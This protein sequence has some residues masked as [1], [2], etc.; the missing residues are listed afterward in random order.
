RERPTAADQVYVIAGDAID[1]ERLDVGQQRH[2]ACA[3]GK[4]AARSKIDRVDAAQQAVDQCIVGIE[5]PGGSWQRKRVEAAFAKAA[6]KPAKARQLDAIIALALVR[7][8]AGTGH[9]QVVA[10]LR[11]QPVAA[12]TAYERIVAIPCQ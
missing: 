6:P 4:T 8:V 9:D 12:R 11:V 1:P 5:N 3:H 7:R 2:V 10:E